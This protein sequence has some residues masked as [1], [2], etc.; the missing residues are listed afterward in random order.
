LNGFDSDD[1]QTSLRAVFSWSYRALSAPAARLF[2]K[3]PMH[4]GPDLTSDAA[5][6]LLDMPPG[7]GRALIRELH[8]GNLVTESR[9]GH[10]EM[11]TLLRSYA[12]ELDEEPTPAGP[13]ADRALQAVTA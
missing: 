4:T 10:F 2:Q 1:A 11:H 7:E 12:T 9:P 8:R 6:A 5:A 13:G 3:I